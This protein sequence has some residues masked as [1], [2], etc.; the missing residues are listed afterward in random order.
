MEINKLFNS[1]PNDYSH[2]GCGEDFNAKSVATF[3][4]LNKNEVSKIT[5]VS[6][7]SVR[8]DEKI[9]HA[10]KERM[11]EIAIIINSVTKIFDGDVSKTILWFKT[12]NPM[13]G[14]IS[15]RD[16]IRL[17]KYEKVRKFII[18]SMEQ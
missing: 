11:E 6:S 7:K 2:F 12:P 15:P 4:D 18:S 14:C 1:V 9:P 8:W 13:L 17:G 3:L 16:L 10:V 5:H